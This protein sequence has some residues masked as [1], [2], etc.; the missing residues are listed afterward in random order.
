MKIFLVTEKAD[1]EQF[2]RDFS[3][4]ESKIFFIHNQLDKNF[5][6]NLTEDCYSIID[7]TVNFQNT[8]NQLIE[9][10]LPGLHLKKL[11]IIIEDNNTAE[12]FIQYGFYNFISVPLDEKGIKIQFLKAEKEQM[13]YKKLISTIREKEKNILKLEKTL[14]LMPDGV[15]MVNQN[16]EITFS[17]SQVE[18]L[19][20]YMPEELLGKDI[21]TLV[22]VK[23]REKHIDYRN[24]Y[25]SS[26]KIRE[27]GSQLEVYGLKK[28]G[29]IFPVDISLSPVRIDEEFFIVST[30]KDISERKQIQNELK[31]TKEAA[32]A[33]NRAKSEFLANMS[34]ELRTPLNAILGYSQILLRDRDLNH[35]QKEEINTIK[36]SGEHLL[37]LISDILDLSKIEFGKMEL[38]PVEFKFTDFINSISEIFKIRAK[39]KNLSFIYEVLTD[40]PVYVNSDEKKLR[41][42]LFN[43]L[44]NALKFTE[45]G[46]IAF[47]VGK[48]DNKIVF[49]VEDTGIGIDPESQN[50]IFLPFTQVSNQAY[51]SEGTGL[52]LSISQ[53]LAEVLGS[54]IYVQSKPG[55]GSIFTFEMVLPEI[56]QPEN[57]PELN[58]NN[59]TG[60]QGERKTILIVDDK[61]ENRTI[62]MDL[63]SPIGFIVFE[64]SDGNDCLI[65]TEKYKPDLIF[66]DLRMPGLDGIETT[67]QI[68]MENKVEGI[69]ILAVSASAFESD[70]DL[71]IE[72]GCNDFIAKPFREEKIFQAIEKFMDLKW[73]YESRD[74]ILNEKRDHTVNFNNFPVSKAAQIK[75]MAEIG[76]S[77]G[78]TEVL[79]K[80]ENPDN[81]YLPE[82]NYILEMVKSFE[83]EK[84]IDL[85][86]RNNENEQ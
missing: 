76:D 80:M 82:I 22:P 41:Q 48:K 66:M 18:Q 12:E 43:L 42:I 63:L 52:G 30:V 64:A 34:H 65:K 85:L 74:T 60:Y 8:I 35:K 73:I 14:Q 71:S 69:V 51:R 81:K 77:Y 55:E 44:S 38:N 16:A 15:V 10:N 47:K 24:N 62:L 84:I 29:G 58:E 5:S 45:K 59:I 9:L 4:N 37:G 61:K 1:I 70:R 49:Q 56:Y 11:F 26:P 72:A 57:L 17:N 40:I 54:S 20:G 2:F 27:M 19:F 28:D 79:E 75:E 78:I 67:K 3:N 83:F 32:E 68:R 21:E 50:E 39:E 33:A 25:I 53:K 13:D 46:G 86:S 31:K 7:T 6:E 23:D 36:A